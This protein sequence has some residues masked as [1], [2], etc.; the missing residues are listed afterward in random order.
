MA[1]PFVTG[2]AGLPGSDFVHQAVATTG[3]SVTVR[4]PSFR[5]VVDPSWMG[6]DQD[7][8]RKQTGC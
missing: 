3:N 7:M 4:E 5:R 6:K 2:D 1:T 8:D